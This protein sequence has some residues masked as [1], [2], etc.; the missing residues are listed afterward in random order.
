MLAE[1]LYALRK[2][3]GLSQEELAE[4]LDVSRQAVSKWELGT[5][6]PDLERL[7]AI[8]R[9]YGVPAD[10]LLSEDELPPASGNDAAPPSG[11]PAAPGEG[12]KKDGARLLPGV[13]LAVLGAVLL[14]F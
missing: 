9:F 4:K 1:K 8:S 3:S 7:A 12:K 11:E 10:A 2:R 14:L 5:A 13:I 6:K